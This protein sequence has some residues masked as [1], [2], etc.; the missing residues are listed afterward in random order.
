MKRLMR[1][2]LRRGQTG[3]TIVI[4][5]FGFI[6]L[7]GFVGIVTDVSLLFVRYSTLR[8]AV[9]SAAVAPPGRCAAPRRRRPKSWRPAIKV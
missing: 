5:A 2:M 1:H 3:Q 6:V 9:D 8:R 7:L 4:M